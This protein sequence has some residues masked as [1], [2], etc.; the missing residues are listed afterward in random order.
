MF[1]KYVIFIL[2]A[3][4]ALGMSACTSSKSSGDGSD[5]EQI[6]GD[7]A[8][9]GADATENNDDLEM[10]D[11]GSSGDSAVADLGGANDDLAPA[12]DPAAM[13]TPPPSSNDQLATN[14]LQETPPPAATDAPPPAPGDAPPPGDA[15][16]A[17]SPPPPP[18]DSPAPEPMASEA[19]PAVASLQKMKS[20]PY[21]QGKILVNAIYFARNGDSP[22]TVSQKVFGTKDK[23]KELCKVNHANCA[24]PT[25]VGDKFYYNS[26]QRP[27]DDTVVKVFYEDAG[28]APQIYT[29]KAGDD[30]RK[31][32]KELLGHERS[33]MEVW[34][35]NEVESKHGLDEGTQLKYWPNSEAA[36]PTQTIAKDEGVPGGEMPPPPPVDGNAPPSPPDQAMNTPPPPPQDQAMNAPPPPPPPPDLPPPPDHNQQMAAAGQIEPPPPPPPPSND[37]NKGK[38]PAAVDAGGLQDPNQTMALGIGA[39]LL[40]A[41][42]A[43]FISIRKKRARR[44]IDFNTTTQTQIE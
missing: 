14:E 34:A 40:L 10:T 24:R 15:P 2:A 28:L 27:T 6:A 23:V 39:V 9:E 43:L 30:I 19:K 32:A 35:T 33:W 17:D 31:I 44:Q 22:E 7:E 36:A 1:R 26:P 12:D 16:M 41:A 5:V 37:M 8:I 38:E 20:Q 4:M 13:T 42:A 18:M 11:K 25:K 29:A 3:F 21:K